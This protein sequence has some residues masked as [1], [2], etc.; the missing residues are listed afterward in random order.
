MFLFWVGCL[1]VAQLYRIALCGE[2]SAVLFCVF[3]YMACLS[4]SILCILEIS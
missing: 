4:P 3:I 2:T 1:C